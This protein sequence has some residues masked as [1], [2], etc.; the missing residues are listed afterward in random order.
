[1]ASHSFI[2]GTERVVLRGRGMC[3][4]HLRRNLW[5]VYRLGESK[6]NLCT[7]DSLLG[8]IIMAF[9]YL[10]GILAVAPCS[11]GLKLLPDRGIVGVT[12]NWLSYFVPIES[13]CCILSSWTRVLQVTSVLDR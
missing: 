8:N 11:R 9:V 6:E 2:L 7:Y 1:M 3:P 12:S 13:D 10:L 5:V 4:L